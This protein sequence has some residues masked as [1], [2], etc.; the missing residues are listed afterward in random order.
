[1]HLNVTQL[2]IGLTIQFNQSEVVLHSNVQNSGEKDKNCSRE[3]LVNVGS[4][5][6][7]STVQLSSKMIFDLFSKQLKHFT[8][9][10]EC[11]YKQ[12]REKEK[13]LVTFS[14]SSSMLSTKLLPLR[15]EQGIV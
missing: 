12:C 8:T 9:L 10:A 14:F 13:M 5:I 1:M 15:S 3:W 7:P 4:E 11:F 6:H 2:L